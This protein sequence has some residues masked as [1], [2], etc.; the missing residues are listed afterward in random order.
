V[1]AT[2]LRIAS[3]PMPPIMRAPAPAPLPQYPGVAWCSCQPPR[4]AQRADGTWGRLWYADG[5]RIVR[6]KERVCKHCETQLEV[7]HADN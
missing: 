7:S 2:L 6:C 5:W 3:T 1:N 4:Y